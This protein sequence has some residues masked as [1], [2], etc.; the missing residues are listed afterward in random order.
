MKVSRFVV[1]VM[2]TLIIICCNCASYAQDAVKLKGY[3]EIM[4]ELYKSRE[5]GMNELITKAALMRLETPYVANTLERG[6][7][8]ELYVNIN[9]TD[10]ILFVESCLALAQTAKSSDTTY[11]N[12]CKKI[13]ELR[14]RDGKVDGYPSRIHYTSEWLLQAEKKGDLSEQSKVIA[15]TP[16]NQNFSYMSVNSDKYKHLKGNAANIA[17]IKKAEDYLN[18]HEYWYIPNDKIAENAHK[19]QTGDIFG[20][21]TSVK[22][23]DLSHVGIVYWDNGRLTFIHASYGE[24]K[25]V[26]ESKTLEEYAKSGKSTIGIRVARAK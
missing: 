18:A 14:Y 8:E 3:H 5:L 24:K 4:A 22:G 6:N 17:K 2:A 9:E 20:F 23:L 13:Q 11:T 7:K 12:F 19:L 10:C 21:C 1:A 15:N 16:L 26:I 25:V